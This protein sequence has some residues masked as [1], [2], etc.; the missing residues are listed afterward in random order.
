MFLNHWLIAKTGEEILAREVFHRFKTYADF[1]SGDRH[2][3]AAR[4]IHRAGQVYRDF[5]SAAGQLTGPI[6][7]LGLFAYRT[8]VME[9]EVVKPLVLFLLD[10]DEA[11]IPDDQLTK[12]LRSSRAG[13][14]GACWCG[15]PPSPTRR[16]SPS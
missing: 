1:D 14:S 7:R 6:D 5:V 15:Q 16:Y 10:P 12:A 8:S 4:Q 2:D 11:A 3:R 9:S 13:W